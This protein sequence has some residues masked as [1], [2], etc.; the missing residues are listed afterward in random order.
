MKL[1]SL[2]VAVQLS[3]STAIIENRPDTDLEIM[4]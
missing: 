2:F 4:E 3:Y 1:S